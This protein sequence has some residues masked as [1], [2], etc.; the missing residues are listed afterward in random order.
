[1]GRVFKSKP[2]QVTIGSISGIMGG[3]FAMPGPPLVL[4]CISTL[5]DKREYVTTLQAFSVVFNVFYTIFRIKA[6]FFTDE[7]SLWWV[8]GIGGAIIGSSIGSR[9]FEIISNRTLKFIVYI[10]MI[11][12]GVIA[13]L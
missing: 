2:A 11:A 12:S 7:I 3:M 6:G 5:D 4:Y 1:M 13:I 9:C 10:I 8:I